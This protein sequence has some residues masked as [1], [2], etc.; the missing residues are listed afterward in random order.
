MPIHFRVPLSI[1]LGTAIAVSGPTRSLS[2]QSPTAPVL[3]LRDALE[4]AEAGAY[5]N[6]IADGMADAQRGQVSGALR[7]ILPSVRM[8][9]GFVRTNDPIGAFGTTLRQRSIT[10]ADF[11]PARLNRPPA[12]SNYQGGAVIEQPIFNADAWVGRRAA[13][14]GL[15]ASRANAQWTRIGTRVDVIR[16][17]YGATLARE[18][19]ATLEAASRAAN[20]HVRQAEAMVRQGLAT[21]SDALL[22]SVGAGEVDAQ[23]ADADAEARTAIRQLAV[24][25]GQGRSFLPVLP[26]SLP[27]AGRIRAVVLAATED[28]AA[29]AGSEREEVDRADV[30]AARHGLD[31]ARLDALR[32][33]SLYLPRLNSFARYDWNSATRLYAGMPSWTVGVMASWSLFA[34]ASEIAERQATAGRVDAARAMADAADESAALEAEQTQNELQA[35]LARLD[36]AERSVQQSAEAHRIVTRKYEGGLATVVELLDAAAVETQSALR[37]SAARYAVITAGAQRLKALG[38]DP[39]TLARLDDASAPIDNSSR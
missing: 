14:S 4:R 7:G 18:K 32:A 36:I 13:T 23:L 29:A 6:R 30:E 2:A 22:A 37:Y 19:T 38:R 12:I 28:A 16:A 8:E 24:A 35:A 25:L 21:R 17:Y 33:R 15:E 27:T 3:T 34:G 1:L 20:A 5:S 9:G 10:Q 26:E 11:D 31:A 39:A